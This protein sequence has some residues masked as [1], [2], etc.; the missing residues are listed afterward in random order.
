MHFDLSTPRCGRKGCRNVLL[1]SSGPGCSECLPDQQM[2][3]VIFVTIRMQPDLCYCTAPL[4]IYEFAAR[5]F[6]GARLTAVKP[7]G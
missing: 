4:V 6:A 5:F 1:L 7:A 2:Q 3:A